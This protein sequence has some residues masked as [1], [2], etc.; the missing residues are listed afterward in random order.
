MTTNRL[1]I[2]LAVLLGGLSTVL[3][4]PKQLSYQPVGIELQL[5]EFNGEW[6]GQEV[7]V[8]E[9]EI[10][11]LGADT[12]FARKNYTNGR[13]DEIQVSIV[14]SGQDMNNSIH[15]PERCLPAQG[16][17]ISDKHTVV[18]PVEG[19]GTVP[20]TCLN[21]VRNITREDKPI[22]IHNVSYYWFAGHTDLTHSHY[23]RAVLDIRD[24]IIHGYNQR[25][26]Y[27][28]VSAV[29]TENLQKFGRTEE[30]TS[31]MIE[32]F[33]KRLVPTLHKDTLKPAPA[34]APGATAGGPATSS[35]A[36][37]RG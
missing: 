31:R 17:T 28:T 7:K 25:W 10:A 24:R 34:P 15:R 37:R 5:P 4:L 18:V 1:A 6:Y 23:E 35:A 20:T 27:I 11:I 33:I 13:G 36:T 29:V 9:R 32:D 22:A 26:A 2:L 21:N 8:S 3:F 16:W 14:L 19:L 12:E 30:Q